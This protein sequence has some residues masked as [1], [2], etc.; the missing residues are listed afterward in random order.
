MSP[1]LIAK[2]SE[3]RIGSRSDQ[4]PGIRASKIGI[5]TC[6]VLIT[7][8]IFILNTARGIGILPD[9]I[10]YMSLSPTPYDAPLYPWLL[11]AIVATGMRLNSGAQVIG[12]VLAGANTL[13]IW[14]FL[15]NGAR[16]VVIATVGTALVILSPQYV[17]LHAVAMSEPLFLF[18]LFLTTVAFLL[19]LTTE[20]H[21]WLILSGILLGTT[22]LVRFTAAPLGAAFAIILLLDRR[23]ASRNR[24]RN[25]FVLSG[26]SA[27]IFFT[28]VIASKLT[29]GHAVGRD[30]AFHG[31]A[32][33]G[34]WTDG[35]MILCNYLLPSQAPDILRIFLFFFVLVATAW[36][37]FP[38][39]NS[40]I[41]T[42]NVDLDN[43]I[44]LTFGLFS[45]TYILFLIISIEVE[46]NLNL[47]SRYALPF[48]VSIVITATSA[49]FEREGHGNAT[50][51][52]RR[53]L[54]AIGLLVV[55]SHALRTAIMT[56]ENYH[57]G[58]GFA[59]HSWA[60]SPTVG[61]V[62]ALPPDATILS[63]A[64]DTLNY[65]TGR[66]TNF[67]P[68]VVQ[69]RTGLEDLSN[70]LPQQ[71]NNIREY[72]R[73]RNTYI[74]FLDRVDWRF[75]LISENDL[76]KSIKLKMVRQERDGRIYALDQIH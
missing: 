63:N 73:E 27:S 12:F 38:K 40:F 53:T 69:R 26:V 71:L 67:I 43:I 41:S 20:R 9:S 55:S 6:L 5:V 76:R 31:N 54:M 13:L 16:S 70:P 59:S 32:D 7:E 36:L 8:L 18:T 1:D 68:F 62:K 24:L 66:K 2:K 60:T 35:F 23:S 50:S 58:I 3:V 51:L 15:L 34:R 44:P 57:H 45:V 29:T 52:I 72:L 19:Y 30:L 75:Y 22:M 11:R 14:F 48:Y 49:L 28:W 46:A 4:R 74:V 47:N 56:K 39:I 64:P 42:G 21:L 61:A 17:G 33:L 37:C 25:L 10:R 65:L